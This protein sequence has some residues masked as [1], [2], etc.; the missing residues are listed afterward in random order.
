MRADLL[1]GQAQ[2]LHEALGLPPLELAALAGVGRRR[3]RHDAGERQQHGQ[4]A[5]D[6]ADMA[7]ATA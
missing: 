1:G 5:T 2:F 3:R 6:E 7:R 4:E